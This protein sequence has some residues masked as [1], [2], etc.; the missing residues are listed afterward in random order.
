VLTQAETGSSRT[1][2][3]SVTVPQ[4]HHIYVMLPMTDAM[5]ADAAVSTAR[6][7]RQADVRLVR[8]LLLKHSTAR[9]KHLCR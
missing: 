8:A 9:E 5:L 7:A 1:C 6:L 2:T 3:S 4:D